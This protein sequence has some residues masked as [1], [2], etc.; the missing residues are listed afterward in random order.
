MKATIEW[1]T[2]DEQKLLIELLLRQQYA[3][4]IVCSEINDIETGM[5]S[6]DQKTYQRLLALYERLRAR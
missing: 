1:L 4:E 6:T 2:I 5:K 3:L